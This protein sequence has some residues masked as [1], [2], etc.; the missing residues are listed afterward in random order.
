MLLRDIDKELDMECKLI[1]N[2]DDR[3]LSLSRAEGKTFQAFLE[4]KGNDKFLSIY[5]SRD[6]QTSHGSTT[7]FLQSVTENEKYLISTIPIEDSLYDLLLAIDKVQSTTSPDIT[8]EEGR[9]TVR[10]CLHHSALPELSKVFKNNTSLKHLVR[11]L[12]VAPASGF[13]SHLERKNKE[14]PLKV[15][16]FSIPYS[17]VKGKDARRLLDK[18]AIAE[19]AS[20]VNTSIQKKV[21]FYAPKNVKIDGIKPISTKSSI[22]EMDFD[23]LGVDIFSVLSNLFN[24]MNIKRFKVFFKKEGVDVRI[25][26]ILQKYDAMRLI[27]EAFSYYQRSDIPANLLLSNDY[28]ES[29]W[30]VL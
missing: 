9:L 18:G 15:L 1:F 6:S 19:P 29:V 4:I 21:I 17:N 26:V 5:V 7:R 28:D 8:V 30:E 24:S 27:S 2:K 14:F 10:V 16:V 3:V 22:Y 13:I 23:D 20:F 11:E 25:I 12:N